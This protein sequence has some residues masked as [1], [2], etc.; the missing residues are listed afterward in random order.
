MSQDFDEL[1]P[2]S[3]DCDDDQ[4]QSR[5][6]PTL[7]T[8]SQKP[9][10]ISTRLDSNSLPNSPGPIQNKCIRPLLAFGEDCMHEGFKR[11]SCTALL[12]LACDINVAIYKNAKW[13]QE[14]DYL[15]YRTHFGN[16]GRMRESQLYAP[17]VLAMHC[18]CR[19]VSVG[20]PIFVESVS[21][22]RWTCRGHNESSV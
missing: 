10:L 20:Q 16:E 17:G 18:G 1:S 6:T 4:P 5:P 3:F 7:P 11:K 8:H 2:N 19:G 13:K 21:G 12:C 14:Y 9:N 22:L 15:Y